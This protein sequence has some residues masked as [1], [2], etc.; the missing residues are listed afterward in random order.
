[1]PLR[2]CDPD[3]NPTDDDDLTSLRSDDSSMYG[4]EQGDM[5][6]RR[7]LRLPPTFDSE[8]GRYWVNYSLE[9]VGQWGKPAKG[10]GKGKALFGLVGE[11]FK[12]V[13]EYRCAPSLRARLSSDH[14]Q[15]CAHSA[16]SRSRLK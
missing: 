14:S 16:G 6:Q 7:M 1:M 15:R 5:S 12:V 4:R 10:K 8:D 13:K 3:G 11:T 9:I 2:N